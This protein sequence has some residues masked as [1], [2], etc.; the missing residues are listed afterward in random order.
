[1]TKNI[2][3]QAS[4]EPMIPA[5]AIQP[6]SEAWILNDERKAVCAKVERIECSF[7]AKQN[8][9][10]NEKPYTERIVYHLGGCTRKRSEVFASKEE[11][12]ASL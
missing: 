10:G 3:T 6:R 11:L 5:D 9:Y 12:L 4:A 2:F 1:M 8:V 7:I